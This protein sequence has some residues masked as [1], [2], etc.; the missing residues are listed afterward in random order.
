MPSTDTLPGIKHAMSHD[1]DGKNARHRRTEKRRMARETATTKQLITVQSNTASE[2][3]TSGFSSED[4]I[5]E[6]SAPVPKEKAKPD[7][8]L[9]AL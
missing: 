5:S 6:I 4:S 1:G 9:K 3:T 8:R 7:A 2:V